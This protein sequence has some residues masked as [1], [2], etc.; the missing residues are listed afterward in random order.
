MARTQG[1]HSEITGPRI[2]ATALALFAEHGYAAVSMRQIAGSVGV[3]VGALYNYIPDKQAL[4]FTLLETHMQEVLTAWCARPLPE[5]ALAQLESFVRFHIPF[6]LERRAAVFISYMELRNLTPENFA[7]IEAL[8]HDYEDALEAILRRGQTEGVFA[9]TDSRLTTYAL[10]AMLTG[11]TT[12]YRPEGRLS[13]EE[14]AGQ[15]WQMARRMV[16][17]RQGVFTQ[18]G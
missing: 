13:P 5:G 16:T 6:H 14:V 3:Q 8:R 7:V 10:L 9:L 11:V 15:Y 2:H 12:W 18:P 1:S 17:P 4:L